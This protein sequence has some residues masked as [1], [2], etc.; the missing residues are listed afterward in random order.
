MRQPCIEAVDFT[1][2]GE[3]TSLFSINS[4]SLLSCTAQWTEV[5]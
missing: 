5:V 2:H 1:V 3:L 4:L